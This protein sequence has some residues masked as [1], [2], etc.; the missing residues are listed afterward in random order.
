MQIKS[1]KKLL[2]LTLGEILIA[3]TIIGI[4]YALVV[5]VL[6]N[7]TD[8]VQMAGMLKKSY[9][10]LNQAIDAS[11]ARDKEDSIKN[12]SFT[13]ASMSKRFAKHLSVQKTCAADSSDCFA[14]S[15]RQFDS[16]KTADYNGVESFI[17]S[18]GVAFQVSSCASDVCTFTFDLNASKAPNF[19]GYDLFQFTFAKSD[20]VVQGEGYA[21]TVMDNG[22]VIDYWD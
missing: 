3:L 13:Q 19:V 2:A 10:V 22:W 15:Y 4:V 8:H 21:K 12:W 7:Q 18:D 20:S 1:F 6:K 11:L 9:T 5:P 14:S 17:L 16:N